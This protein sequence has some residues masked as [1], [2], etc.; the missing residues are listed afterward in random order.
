MAQNQHLNAAR[1]HS[2][3]HGSKAPKGSL[4]P[5]PT[6][7]PATSQV[8]GAVTSSPQTKVPG[9]PIRYTPGARP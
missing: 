9:K 3:G 8:P 6:N 5:T 1:Y 4:P 2:G 7:A